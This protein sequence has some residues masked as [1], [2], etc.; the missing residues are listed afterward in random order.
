MKLADI[1]TGLWPLL[2]QLFSYVGITLPELPE[3]PL[4]DIA[5]LLGMGEEETTVPETTV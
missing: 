5:G 1:L 2:T 3:F 4:F